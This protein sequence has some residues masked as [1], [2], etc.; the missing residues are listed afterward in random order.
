M[1]EF[2]EILGEHELPAAESPAK[3]LPKQLFGCPL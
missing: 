1:Y 2:A 3:Q